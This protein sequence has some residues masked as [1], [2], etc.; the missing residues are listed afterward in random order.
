MN[1]SGGLGT[2]PKTTL[3]NIPKTDTIKE[4]EE[5]EESSD[6]SDSNS[7]SGSSREKVKKCGLTVVEFNENM[8]ENITNLYH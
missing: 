3:L 4:K 6:S 2:S 5:S 1:L 8:I 7:S